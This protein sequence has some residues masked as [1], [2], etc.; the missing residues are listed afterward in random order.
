MDDMYLFAYPIELDSTN[1]IKLVEDLPYLLAF[2]G[3]SASDLAKIIGVTRQSINNARANPTHMSGPMYLSIRC[4][5]L[6]EA[7]TNEA[8]RKAICILNGMYG[9]GCMSR[10]ELIGNIDIVKR[11][12]GTKKGSAEIAKALKAWLLDNDYWA[13]LAKAFGVES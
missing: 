8:L 9:G 3:W 5:V 4:V 2:C 6:D 7:V 10:I 1:K 11:R 12:V 13:G